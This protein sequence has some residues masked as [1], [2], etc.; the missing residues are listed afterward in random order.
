MEE[1]T[2]AGRLGVGRTWKQT[3]V[4]RIG[5]TG[6]HSIDPQLKHLW[7][8]RTA[9]GGTAG[10]GI[11]SPK[12]QEEM[13]Q[14]IKGWNGTPLLRALPPNPT[15]LSCF[16]A[17]WSGR[18]EDNQKPPGTCRRKTRGTEDEGPVFCQQELAG[19]RKRVQGVVEEN[20]SPQGE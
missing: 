6:P 18:A 16:L 9:V 2:E 12:G 15:H 13:I 11:R 1:W 14:H 19:G 7:S 5:G 4:R 17:G 3:D 10:H 20:I 8:V